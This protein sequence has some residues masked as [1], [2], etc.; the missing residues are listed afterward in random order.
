VKEIIL[1]YLKQVDVIPCLIVFAFSLWMSTRPHAAESFNSA[2][3]AVNVALQASRLSRG[4]QPSL[5]G[6]ST[7]RASS[8]S[9]SVYQVAYLDLVDGPIVFDAPAGLRAKLMDGFQRPLCSEGAIG[10]RVWCGDVGMLGPDRGKG[11]TYVI[12]PPDFNGDVPPEFLR[13][14]SRTYG[15]FV[16]WRGEEDGNGA[17][18]DF[19]DA[20][21]RSAPFGW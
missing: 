21:W 4:V 16:L 5:D 17:Q 18:E 15:V 7:A 19:V 3:P 8:V 6:L 12:L 13:L 9:P 20:A 10:G 11:A 14:R 2:S 1:K